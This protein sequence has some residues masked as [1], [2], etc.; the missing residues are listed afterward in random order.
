MDRQM[1]L[2][3]VASHDVKQGVIFDQQGVKV[4]AFVVDH[5]PV[6]PAFGYR[7]DYRGRSVGLSGD[8]RMSENLTQFAKGVDV[9]V[10][11]TLTPPMPSECSVKPGRPMRAPFKGPRTCSPSTSASR[12]RCAALRDERCRPPR[13][14]IPYW[15]RVPAALLFALLLVPGALAGPPVPQQPPAARVVGSAVRAA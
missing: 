2:R 12:L 6:T 3:L 14:L 10:H 11:D 5:S 1:V 4:T 7:I 13:H 9:L 15:R 8:T